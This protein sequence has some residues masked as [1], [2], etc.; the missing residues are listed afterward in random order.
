MR[1]AKPCSLVTL[2][3]QSSTML[4]TSP[5][6]IFSCNLRSSHG[7]GERDTWICSIFETRISSYKP[8]PKILR[9]APCKLEYWSWQQNPNVEKTEKE[10]FSTNPNFH[11]PCCMLSNSPEQTE[12]TGGREF[13]S[14]SK[15]STSLRGIIVS[16]NISG[17]LEFPSSP[18]DST[19]TLSFFS[20]SKYCPVPTN[21][22]VPPA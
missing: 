8:L 17:G 3:K 5:F 12:L 14:F 18:K 20:S 11:G 13:S 9:Y 6:F 19:I 22:L 2:S 21:K 1:E 15:L 4:T 7:S 10:G 16:S